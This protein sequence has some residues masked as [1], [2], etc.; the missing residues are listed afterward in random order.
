MDAPMEELSSIRK[1]INS[2]GVNINQIT[3]SFHNAEAASQKAF[4]AL[5]VA[6][7]YR[8]VG[9]KVDALLAIVSQL[10]IKWLQ[11]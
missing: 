6:E 4:H 2:I 3:H 7:Q 8:K 10:S 11:K 5:K 9:D 1:E